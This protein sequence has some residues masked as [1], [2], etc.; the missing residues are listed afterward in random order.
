MQRLLLA[1]AGPRKLCEHLHAQV[2]QRITTACIRGSAARAVKDDATVRAFQRE[3]ACRE[4]EIEALL[5]LVARPEEDGADSATVADGDD[6][7]T[8]FISIC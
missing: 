4:H 3:R 5:P 2:A 6:L 1:G 7:S 8:A